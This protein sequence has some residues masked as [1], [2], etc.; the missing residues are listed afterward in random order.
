MESLADAISSFREKGWKVIAAE[1]AP[2]AANA[3]VDM[4]A[5]PLALVLGNE[6]S[7]LSE[8]DLALCDGVLAIPMLGA[9]ASLNVS[10]AAGVFFYKALELGGG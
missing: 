2:N 9:K 8:D 6:V 5:P 10:V 3:L 1:D 7:G 4:P